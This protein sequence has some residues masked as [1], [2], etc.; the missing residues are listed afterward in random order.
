MKKLMLTLLLP[1]AV[2]SCG[3]ANVGCSDE[4]AT[5]LVIS[6][7]KDGIQGEVVQQMSGGDVNS[8]G[9]IGPSSARS[10]LDKIQFTIEDIRTAEESSNSTAR[11][12]KGA[13]KINF[14]VDVLN[15]ANQARAQAGMNNVR[16]MAD[17]NG[18]KAAADTFTHEIN[19]TIQPTD[20]GKKIY[21]ETES[22]SAPSKFISEVVVNH[23]SAAAIQRTM[24]EQQAESQRLEAEQ[25]AAESAQRKAALQLATAEF[26]LSTQVINAVWKAIDPDTRNQLLPVQRAWIA[27]TKADCRIEAAAASTEPD[28]IEAARLTC[29]SGRNTSRTGELRQFVSSGDAAAYE[30]SSGE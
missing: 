18:L 3:K 17:M 29:E 21:A 27:K 19:F 16:Q 2:A 22:P 28:A 24:Q 13:L 4:E 10:V 11:T 7:L 20:D 14:P 25:S 26:K 23:L 15:S 30:S 6:L 8:L 9:G 12:C 5:G 1:L